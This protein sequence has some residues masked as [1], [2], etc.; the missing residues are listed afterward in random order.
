MTERERLGGKAQAF[1]EDLWQRNDPWAFES[2]EFERQRYGRL[3]AV[4]QSRRYGRSL[5]IGCGAGAFTRL[6]ASISDRVVALDVSPTA[7]ARA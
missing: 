1:F 7:I 5:E 6:L 2:S 3:F 4:L